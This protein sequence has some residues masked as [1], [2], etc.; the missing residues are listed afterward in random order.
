MQ[1]LRAA[2]R[3]FAGL[4]AA[5]LLAASLAACGGSGDATQLLQQTFGGS[6]QVNSGKLDLSL[7]ITPSGSRTLTAPITLTFGGPFQTRG[8]GKLPESNFTLNLS[9]QGHTGTLGILS[10]GSS[11]FVT[12]SGAAYQLPQATFQRLES[13]FSSLANSPGG[14]SSN[15]LSK[16]G[17]NPLHWLSDATVVGDESVAGTT[18]V[19]IHAKI[20]V[21]A[22]LNDL[23]RVLQRSSASGLTGSSSLSRGL[24]QATV[25][26]I[27]DEV[28]N[29]SFDLWTGKADKTL[30]RMVI[31]LNIPVTG[32]ISSLLGG[33]S[34]AGIGLNLEYDELNLPQSISTPTNVRPFSEFQA[35]LSTFV[36]N[37][38]STL[39]SLAGGGS[40]LP[41]TPG[42]STTGG[43]TS[44]GGGSAGGSS[45][46]SQAYQQCLQ[47]AGGDVGKMQQCASLLN[48][49]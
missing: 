38:R 32:Q 15:S 37:I 33:L 19:H 36:G 42:T 14:S 43:G 41:L 1:Q 22:F 11:G 28:Q 12:L 21:A 35:K 39:G 26:R 8:K 40:G 34:S 23:N 47:Q 20:N 2:P 10:T 5:S 4:L 7:T 45:S 16:L 48:G 13:S 46:G 49:Q 6:H 44:T 25:N 27:A 18:A 17:I 3:W 30:R 29:P 9:A 31:N 24:P